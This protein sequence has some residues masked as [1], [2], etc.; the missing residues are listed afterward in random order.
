MTWWNFSQSKTADKRSQVHVVWVRLK[1]V[2]DLDLSV[3][4]KG[5]PSLPADPPLISDE[6][7]A[8]R[9]PTP[10]LSGDLDVPQLS[11]SFSISYSIY[12]I[13]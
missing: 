10:C 12:F 9:V 1:A 5:H 13:Q 11:V 2:V 4:G 7:E 8:Q 6:T 3:R